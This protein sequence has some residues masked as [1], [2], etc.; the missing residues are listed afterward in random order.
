MAILARVQSHDIAA[1]FDLVIQVQFFDDNDPANTGVGGGG[2]PGV[3]L[4]Y[5]SWSYPPT[6]EDPL[7]LQAQ[8]KADIKQ[9]LVDFI[10]ARNASAS[11]KVVLPV[12]A[13][14]SE[15]S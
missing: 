2:E 12:G 5:D 1:D 11:A 15:S 14:V 6:F 10:R 4:R 7:V 8:V 13:L 9:R 3:V